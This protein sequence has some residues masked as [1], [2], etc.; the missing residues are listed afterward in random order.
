M[1]LSVLS[2]NSLLTSAQC[3]DKILPRRLSAVMDD[4]D[5]CRESGNSMLPTRYIYIYI[6]IV[7]LYVCVLGVVGGGVCVW[8]FV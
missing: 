6:Y 1:E 2:S 8:K 3:R 5:R 7:C 4:K